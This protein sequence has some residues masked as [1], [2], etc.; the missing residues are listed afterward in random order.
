MDDKDTGSLKDNKKMDAN[1]LWRWRIKHVKKYSRHPEPFHYSN[2]MGLDFNVGSNTQKKLDLHSLTNSVILEVC[3]FAE[4]VKRNKWHFITNILEN[5]FD[6]GLKSEQQRIEFTSQLLHKVRHL[7]R[8][9]PE[10]KDEGFTLFDTSS[11]PEFTSNSKSRLNMAS[12]E[13]KT[14]CFLVDMDDMDES[15]HED[16]LKCSR[17]PSKDYMKMEEMDGPRADDSDDVDE[18]ECSEPQ[19]TEE[20]KEDVIPPSFPCCTV[21]GLNLDVESKQS[22]DPGLLT[23]GM[24]LELV[25][26]TR[27]LTASDRSIVLSVLEHNFELDLK[28]QQEKNQVWFTILQLQKR[29]KQLLTTGTKIS[30]EFKSE[31][32]S[33][34]T[35]P[36]EKVSPLSS[37]R[38]SLYQLKEVSKRRQSDLKSKQEKIA[39]S[40]TREHVTKRR[41]TEQAE[42]EE[43]NTISHHTDISQTSE[44]DHSYMCPLDSDEVTD[45]ENDENGD[46]LQNP[47]S[48]DIHNESESSCVGKCEPC[49]ITTDGSSS[50]PNLK[51]N[52]NPTFA[53]QPDERGQCGDEE[54][55]E[56]PRIVLY[57]CDMDEKEMETESNM[58]KL[59]VNR[60][61][62]ILSLIDKAFTKSKTFGLEFNVGF[63]PKQNF[64]VDSLTTFVL[65]EIAKFA[66]AMNS[67]QQDFI[68]EILEYNFDFGLWSEHHRKT[69]A[70]E[71]MNRVR[72]LRKSE[73]SVKLSKEYFELPDPM[74][75]V[76]MTR[77]SMG[78]VN[79]EVSSISRTTEC[80]AAPMCPP[81]SH[82]ETKEHRMDLYPFCKDIGL[83]LNVISSQPNK[84]LE[85]N[86][87]TNGAMTEVTNFAEKLCGTFDQICL[88]ILRHNF[89]LDSQN[90][91]SD[92]AKTILTRI[93]VI[94]EHKNLSN[95]T[96][97]KKIKHTMKD[98]ST[99]VMDYQNYPTL[100][101]CS[102]G[103]SQAT[104]IDQNVGSSTDNNQEN[105]LNLGLWKLRTNQTQQILSVPHVE[106]CPF[107]SYSRCKKLGIDFNVGSGVKQNLDPKF[108]TNGIM[109]E[110]NTLATAL[111]SAQKDFITEILEYN[112]CLN[113]NNEL[114]RSVFAQQ[115]VEK[116]N[117]LYLKS[118][119]PRFL[120]MPF[121]LPDSR[122]IEESR[123]PKTKY[124]PKCYQDRNSKLCQNESKP[125]HQLHPRPDAMTDTVSAE[126]NCTVQK[127]TKD[128]SSAF[129]QVEETIM[130]SYPLCKK[131]GLSLCVDTDKPKVKLDICALTR[132]VMKEI[133]S[134]AKRLCGTKHKLINDVL[135]HNFNFG[136]L[137]QDLN[138]ALLFHRMV[139]LHNKG[140]T[141]F[142]DVFVVYPWPHRDPRDVS[143]Q[144]EASAAQKN[145]RKETTKKRKL[146]LQTRKE[147]AK[148]MSESMVATKAKKDKKNTGDCYPIC[149]EIGLGLEL[150]NPTSSDI[151][152]ESESSYLGVRGPFLITTDCSSSLPIVNSNVNPTFAS[153]PDE[154]GL[155]G[156]E[157]KTEIPR[158]VPYKCDMKE[159]EM[160]VESNMW[161][162]RANRVKQILF[163]LDKE[164]CAFTR[165]KTFGLEF[166]VGFVQKKNFSVDSLN[167][168]VLLEIAK[169][170][171]AMNSSQQ[172]FI[173]EILEYNF[174]FGLWSEHHRKTFACE[175]MN[176]VRQLK[177]SD[178]AVKLS[179]EVFEL[180]DP[181]SS[182]NMASQNMGS[183]NPEVRRISR[184]T[185]CDIAPSCPPDLQAET[186]EHRVAL[187]PF[188]KDI[189]LKLNVIGSQPNKKLEINKLTNGAMTEVTNFA[190]KLCGTFDQICLDILRH[191]FDLD[192]Q[193]GDS[194]LAK[195]I[196]ARIPV[197][198][199]QKHLSNLTGAKK[200]KHTVKDFSVMVMDC[201][202]NPTLD[203]CSTGSSQAP[204]IDQNVGSSTDNEQENELNL[205]L[206]KLR[207]N[208]IQ[209]ILSVPHGEHCL[210]YY[211][212]RCK[213]LGIDFNVG[214][215]VKQNL[216][217][218]LL[219]NGI[220]VE[221][222]TFSTAMQSAQKDFI[223]E[224]LE[225]NFHLYLKNEVCRNVFAQQVLEKIRA[226][227]L[228]FNKSSIMKMPFELPDSKCIEEVTY[229]KTKYCPKCYQDRNSKLHQDESDPDHVFHPRPHV[230]TD[231][232]STEANCTAQKPTKDLFSTFQKAE[233]TI[234][235]SYPLCK[236]V[237]LS[238]YVDQ[239]KPKDKLDP[240]VLTRGMMK[241]VAHFSKRLCG[242]KNKL[243][244]DVLEH[245]FNIGMQ[246]QDINPAV[247]F[248]KIVLHNKG[249]TWFSEVFVIQPCPHRDTRDVRKVKEAPSMQKNERKE[250][251][252]KRKLALQTKKE[253]ATLS[254]EH[255]GAVKSKKNTQCNG[256]RF[257]VCSEIGLNLDVSSK[258]GDKEKLDLKL[259]TRAAVMEI[260]RYL[261]KKVGHYFPDSLYDILDYNFDISSQ[262]YRRW[263][264]SIATASKVKS[265]GKQYRKNLHR[266]KEVF[267]LPFVFQHKASKRSG[268]ERQNMKSAISS[269][270]ETDMT[271]N[272]EGRVVQQLRYLSDVNHTHLLDVKT[273]KELW[274]D[275]KD[276]K[277]QTDPGTIVQMTG[278]PVSGNC[279]SLLQGNIQIKEEE[280]DSNYGTMKPVTEEIVKP[281]GSLGYTLLTICPKSESRIK[282][283]SET[284]DAQYYNLVEPQISEGYA[285]LAVGKETE[286][287]VKTEPDTEEIGK[288]VGSIGYTSV[289]ICPKSESHIKTESETEDAHHYNLAE[290]QVSEGYAML[291]VC[292]KS[293]KTESDTE[294]VKYEVPVAVAES[295]A[296]PMITT[297]QDTESISIKEEQENVP[298]E[299][300]HYG[301][302][303]VQV[304]TQSEVNIKQEWDHS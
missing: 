162:L 61:K 214:S 147:E 68:M 191:N 192:W 98:F 295:G 248:H 179:K 285:M 291:A 210:F 251:T 119:K 64:N 71:I 17:A 60:V 156:D 96:G 230:M 265:M 50:L 209:Q 37:V 43:T 134:F 227:A 216:D 130:D 104:I 187:Y 263:E 281:G 213:K 261:G 158:N 238:L 13:Y 245:N 154:R 65:L 235:D 257:P 268:Q 143:K 70:C 146:A 183:V 229:Q 301:V 211:Y 7:I 164:Y 262:N 44:D 260:Y 133:T 74:S 83:K 178:D 139:A 174:D 123:Y 277:S 22:L 231:T 207:T 84:K 34:Q 39:L 26:F 269:L 169:F 287:T 63:G 239:D 20:L 122:S 167:N 49:L 196:L 8:K 259:L 21:I 193:N 48:S 177:S 252:K 184:T 144:T 15:E 189:G 41:R 125:D 59:R 113:L 135:E 250:T 226:S 40:T 25:Q 186:K 14:D 181:M 79:P 215:G 95:L 241:E 244:N 105:E 199:E 4:T 172:D 131:I 303:Q 52:V 115:V 9:P 289:T 247:L 102:I 141:W 256:D 12:T 190:E 194:D 282:T 217:P 92:L 47:T 237:G 67:S 77:Q 254:S 53:N 24:M 55:T 30:P 171:I 101:T 185:E 136:K 150:E 86:K 16:K 276:T 75:S 222:N 132:G 264:F 54:K 19:S 126:A 129:Q 11:G 170:S 108:L 107:Y 89:D 176:R 2:K 78:S 73:D 93:P 31:P 69:F 159:E 46:D 124:C 148:I 90:G 288:P 112:F 57:K 72:Q 161:K 128:L 5:N 10:D 298:V 249:P 284:E 88:D 224:I 205:G 38:A 117:S 212:S 246:S 110:V 155:C 76:N 240:R 153:Q 118:S 180:P 271:T 168:S 151:H 188:C 56:I 266:A 232:V 300:Y 94:M 274:L 200:I 157:K 42:Q 292:T 121:E 304:Q 206:W 197:I 111:Q 243:I 195:T 294:D 233:D 33:F 283:E 138:P 203:A 218:K 278:N 18:L 81:D 255:M 273:N 165:S 182:V 99:M 253:E 258:S 85:M 208:Q 97:F 228:K 91:D 109:V 120:K 198:M 127:P 29:K 149:T 286:S 82:T 270:K 267:K 175:V 58:W 220:M 234:M 36:F 100:D 142:S 293:V 116:I 219:T 225:Y 166:N 6:L 27:T 242:T 160:E 140:P 302:V 106:H 1:T 35:N 221:I 145:E 114:C 28:C 297:C 204:I 275:E 236:K 299:S 66:L 223:T 201:Q 45:S 272:G 290:P 103:S 62:Q 296:Y 32:F 280:D 3:D 152:T 23:K 279:D 137:S 173:M 163:S 51:S 80:D 202:N 87:L